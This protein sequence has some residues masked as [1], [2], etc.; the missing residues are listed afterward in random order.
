M[1]FFSSEPLPPFKRK[2]AVQEYDSNRDE[3]A[4]FQVKHGPPPPCVE[5]THDSAM[6]IEAKRVLN[7]PPDGD[8]WDEEDGQHGEPTSDNRAR[9]DFIGDNTEFLKAAARKASITNVMRS[10]IASFNGSV[11]EATAVAVIEIASRIAEAVVTLSSADNKDASEDGKRRHMKMAGQRVASTHLVDSKKNI[12]SILF[13]F[14][15]F[16]IEFGDWESKNFMRFKGTGISQNTEVQD[17]FMKLTKERK[18][19]SHAFVGMTDEEI[20]KEFLDKASFEREI[21]MANFSGM[22]LSLPLQC[23]EFCSVC[24]ETQNSKLAQLQR[25]V[26]DVQIMEENGVS[27]Q[28]FEVRGS[29]RTEQTVIQDWTTLGKMFDRQ[30]N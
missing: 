15:V 14:A 21:T 4:N 13:D 12:Y 6:A 26:R 2:S 1:S 3:L 18:L 20:E 10:N 11:S 27:D 7:A 9:V 23:K 8:P 29:D 24:I 19:Q 30:S 17:L 28:L 22:L 25:V 5:D 16:T